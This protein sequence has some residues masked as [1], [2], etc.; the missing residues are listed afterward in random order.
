M[1]CA[2]IAILLAAAGADAQGPRVGSFL[3]RVQRVRDREDVCVLVAQDGNYR[4][5]RRFPNETRVYVG[6]M[7]PAD[8]QGLESIL[9]NDSLK[10]ISQ[11]DIPRTLVENSRDVLLV[12]VY[13]QE[14]A[15][16][17]IFPGNE[18]RKPFQAALDPVLEW[19]ANL[20][21]AQHAEISQS[22]AS[23]CLPAENHVSSI[24][25]LPYLLLFANNR[26]GDGLAETN[27]VIVY[28]DGSYRRERKTQ[29][30]G[31]SAKS[32]KVQQASGNV[33]PT[34]LKQLADLLNSKPLVRLQHMERPTHWSR[35]SEITELSI[36]RSTGIQKLEFANEYGVPGDPYEIGGA[37][38]LNAHLDGKRRVLNPLR[39]WLKE[40]VRSKLIEVSATAATNC[41]GPH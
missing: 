19:F 29:P 24:S 31:T 20:Q 25:P 27:C 16:R 1:F 34:N 17:L 32:M 5:E 33:A 28:R 7:P 10:R 13:R 36:P 4:L 40:N 9:G 39:A 18:S 6:V 37:S 8:L 38:G 2:V 22:S 12:D 41:A 21:K 23:H 35:E 30:F 26:A 14:V 15:Q 11:Q 3:A